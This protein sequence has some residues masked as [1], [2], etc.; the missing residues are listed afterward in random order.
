[1][2]RISP[3]GSSTG[4]TLSPEDLH[5]L[6]E[7]R[8][9][10]PHRILG[11]RPNEA[12]GADSQSMARVFHP[13]ALSVVLQGCDGQSLPLTK[14]HEEGLFEAPAPTGFP[15][16]PEGYRI[17]AT[18]ADGTGFSYA[19]PNA[20]A[21]TLGEVD[22]Y[23]LGQGEHFESYRVLGAHLKTISGIRGTSFA[24]W[25][26]NAQRVSV[27]GDFNGW[28]G[29]RHMMRRLGGSGIWEIFAPGVAEGT[30]YKFE[31]RGPHGDVF[32]KTDP[33]GFFAQHDLRT[34]CM[35]TDLGRY[36]WSDSGWMER[37][38]RRDACAEPM[39]V[40]EVHLGSWR[41]CPEEQDRPLSYLELTE[42]LVSYVTEMGFTHVE[43]LPVMEHPF[44]GSWGYQV[45]NFFAPSSRF[46]S[47]DE[48]RHLIDALHQAGIG[49]ILDWVPGHFPK[50]AHGLARFDGT[51]LYEHEDPR[52]GEHRDW[53]T[54]IFNYGRN[55]VRN[56]LIAN[57]LFWL[58]QYHIDGLRVDAV[59]SMLYLDYS[60]NAG[61]WVPNRFGGRE[62]LEAIEFLKA[63]N[64]ACY[65]RHPGIMTIAEESTAWPG[66]SKPVYE[67]G[68]G[69]GFKWNMGW[70][71]DSLRYIARPPIHRKYHQGEITFSM[72]YAYH[73]HF[74][75]VL[76]HDE[77]VH[78]KGSLLN[79]MPGDDWQKA[80]NLRMFL[81]W[82][83]AHPGKKLLFQGGEF[84]QWREWDHDHSIDWHLLDHQPHSGMR[85]L[86][87]RLNAI[88][89]GEPALYALDD[90]PE[91]FRWVDFLD[92]E[93]SV[94]SFLRKAPESPGGGS[95]SPDLLVIVNATPVVRHGYRIGVPRAGSCEL[96]LD[97]DGIEFGGSGALSRTV[98]P[99]QPVGA[100]GF[101]HSV[102]LDLPPLAT[103][104]LRLPV[105]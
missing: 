95:G 1:M 75:L 69:F 34:A 9:S 49:V 91:G 93:N 16:S 59:A 98:F 8:H 21:P 79:K 94:W 80:A 89:R 65:A 48:F 30:H 36:A 41:R 52:L 63:F 5:P 62:N 27:V 25:A 61:E 55:E 54:L 17:E 26:P 84:A 76:S 72:L 97:S 99:A 19:D 81:S 60:R 101:D 12:A 46:G 82:M 31:I 45:V 104:I 102:T 22:L 24:V 68:L 58:D 103:L 3:K 7:C 32:L 28:D 90:R 14:V 70:M 87:K 15:A 51:A 74:I 13:G 23:L 78:G 71:N 11:I 83:W 105:N 37:R 40:Y 77:V 88:Y 57:A 4:T 18:F 64:T 6:L 38:A 10:D 67:G 66:V 96:I 29:R 56:F 35:V 42:Q 73:E 33:Y 92:A 2:K 20:F 47:P 100:H 44:D 85:L 86:V 39:S 53:G 50:D 43:L